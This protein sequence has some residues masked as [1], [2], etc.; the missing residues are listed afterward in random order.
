MKRA[1]W[2]GPALALGLVTCAKT[3]V[4]KALKLDVSGIPF[5][6]S[7][8][9]VT[10][11]RNGTWSNKPLRYPLGGKGER[12]TLGLLLGPGAGAGKEVA[13]WVRAVSEAGCVLAAE[14][15]PAVAVAPLATAALALQPT[16]PEVTRQAV[17]CVTQLPRI[18]D[19]TPQKIQP[20]TQVTLRA[21]GLLDGAELFVDGK[22]VALG[23]GAV[24][25]GADA[26][27]F[28]TVTFPAP[29]VDGAL[30]AVALRLRN[31]DGEEDSRPAG[32]APLRYVASSL[33]F[34]AQALKTADSPDRVVIADLTG[35]GRPD[36][37]L[38]HIDRPGVSLLR[39]DGGSFGAQ[40]LPELR[41][42]QYTALAAAPLTPGGPLA[43]LSGDNR[44]VDGTAA[45]AYEDL[46]VMPGDARGGIEAS[47]IRRYGLGTLVL[48]AAA[49]DLR[50][51]GL[52][53][54]VLL[55]Y[56]PSFGIRVLLN[57]GDNEFPLDGGVR[58][59][60][61]GTADLRVLDVNGD[62]KL[63]LAAG[64]GGNG[65]QVEVFLGRGDGSFLD[66]RAVEP[67]GGQG[68]CLVAA[69]LDGRGGPD[70]AVTYDNRPEGKYEV[71]VAL[72]Q[73][74]DGRGEWQ[75]T[76]AAQAYPVDP[77]PG[78][79]LSEDVDGD[80]ARDLI[81]GM[82]AGP[83]HAEGL[84]RVLRNDG[85]GRFTLLAP[86]IIS[87]AGVEIRNLNH[88]AVGDLNGDRRPDLVSVGSLANSKG[89]YSAILYLSQPEAP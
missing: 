86:E 59:V 14:R 44:R 43:I 28:S 3:D 19:I 77:Y 32:A 17:G 78:C 75:G 82:D 80:G 81:V 73:G 38:G 16:P 42:S 41:S 31:P 9:L 79:V 30:G 88:L 64:G 50:G 22:P 18:V 84:V 76:G 71:R 51:R 13:L 8:L 60:V 56:N 45:A 67:S 37:L 83:Q 70:F 29:T 36:L 47:K 23:D 11:K 5:G 2:I 53:D 10:A 1:R 66:R 54:L 49:G 6:A 40:A 12:A 48:G 20:G 55:T 65:A 27:Q 7:A 89:V 74:L 61:S 15:S 85:T 58:Y 21:W 35:D 62:G 72:N 69:D 87:A 24:L 26:T 4:D 57:R 25:P 34:V 63:D 33:R 52:N 46:V 68:G 39:N